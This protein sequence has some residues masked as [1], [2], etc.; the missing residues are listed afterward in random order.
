LAVASRQ[1]ISA[2]ARAAN[3]LASAAYRNILFEQK[4]PKTTKGFSFG[5]PNTQSN[6][7]TH[8]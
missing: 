5:T 7:N 2:T 8:S 1:A 6:T 3:V 4:T